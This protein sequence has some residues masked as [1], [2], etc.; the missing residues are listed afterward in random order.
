[1]HDEIGVRAAING[2]R[3]RAR[4][5]SLRPDPLAASMATQRARGL[6]DARRVAH[7]IDTEGPVEALQ[8][9]QVRAGVIVEVIARGPTLSDAGGAL[10]SS[11]TH[12]ARLEEP[13]PRV[14]GVGSARAD[15]QVYVVALLTDGTSLTAGAR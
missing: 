4:V 13:S 3:R 5:D 8:R 10:L 11:P 14:I 12:R 2:L 1:M 7:V 9:A 15:G 6:A